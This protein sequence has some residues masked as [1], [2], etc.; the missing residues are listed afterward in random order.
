MTLSSTVFASEKAAPAV[1]FLKEMKSLL[2]EGEIKQAAAQFFVIGD[3]SYPKMIEK[4]LQNGDTKK[5]IISRIDSCLESGKV[6]KK[7]TS[8]NGMPKNTTSYFCFFKKE[9]KIAKLGLVVYEI[10]GRVGFGQKET[11]SNIDFKD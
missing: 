1:K 8:H 7:K 9:E 3:E 10:D 2:S 11:F 5:L 4:M 6:V